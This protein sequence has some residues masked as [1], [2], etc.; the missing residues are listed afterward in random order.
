[1]GPLIGITNRPRAEVLIYKVCEGATGQPLVADIDL[2]DVHTHKSIGE[3]AGAWSVR[4]VPLSRAQGNR[5]RWD[6]LIAAGDYVEI[7]L[8]SGR[9]KMRP[10]KPN[11]R[12][13]VDNVGRGQEIG[14]DENITHYVHCNGRDFGGFLQDAQ[15]YYR[16]PELNNVIVTFMPELVTPLSKQYNIEFT[17]YQPDR[18]AKEV[19]DKIVNEEHLKIIK[20]K[21]S[22]VPIMNTAEKVSELKTI[23]LWSKS[24]QYYMGSVWE[25]LRQYQNAPWYE[26][27]VQEGL[28]APE[29]VFRQTPWRDIKGAYI[30][31]ETEEITVTNANIYADET[32][33]SR[34]ELR[35]YFF[36]TPARFILLKESF[37]AL[38]LTGSSGGADAVK[39]PSVIEDSIRQ[40]G[41]RPME[42]ETEWANVQDGESAEKAKTQADGIKLFCED[43]NQRMA[44]AFKDNHLM[45]SGTLQMNGNTDIAMGTYLKAKEDNML[46]YVEG[47][48]HQ[49]VQFKTFKTTATVT[50]GVRLN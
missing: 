3:P 5:V 22:K 35:N 18:W 30:Q 41:L 15:V 16:I 46:Y 47:V 25:L 12:G 42:V 50:R 32:G 48:D 17:S 36:T 24:I 23:E 1:M 33:I 43:L 34:N 13:F 28:D 20:A 19:V 37:K 29:L 44:K 49:L 6:D 45:R 27:F 8:S 7:Y 39:N 26:M 4:M 10:S 9:D 2:I 21:Q 38:V 14:E 31:G 40:H 11:M